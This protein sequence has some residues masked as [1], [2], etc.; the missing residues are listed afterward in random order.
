MKISQER[1][2][3]L[4]QIFKKDFN[5]DF[6]DQELHDAAFNLINFYDALFRF[7]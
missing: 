7:Y 6:N 1:L 4:R 3:E 2:E 5:T